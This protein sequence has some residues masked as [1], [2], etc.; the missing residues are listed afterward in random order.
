MQTMYSTLQVIRSG[1]FCKKN[2]STIDN[3]GSLRVNLEL[4]RRVK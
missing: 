3:H 2:D 4:A 1:P